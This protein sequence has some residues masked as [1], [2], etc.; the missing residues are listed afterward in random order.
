MTDEPMPQQPTWEMVSELIAKYGSQENAAR[1]IRQ[2]A[3]AEGW[4]EQTIAKKVNMNQSSVWKIMNPDRP[5]GRRNVSIQDAINFS[6]IFKKSLAELLLPDGV[7]L[8]LDGWSAFLESTENLNEVRDAARLYS[9]AIMKTRARLSENTELR[10]R[11]E[12]WLV[13]AQRRI[14][15]QVLPGWK[16]DGGTHGPDPFFDDYVKNFRTPAV[17]AAEDALGNHYI[18]R[19]LWTQTGVKP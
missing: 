1:R 14:R 4:S 3:E 2:W 6:R 5:S 16:N 9:D 12:Q 15:E 19:S 13:D 8:H 7:M 18:N 10:E 11:I 17:I